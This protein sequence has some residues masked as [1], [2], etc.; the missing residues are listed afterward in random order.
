MPFTKEAVKMALVV[1]DAGEPRPQDFAV[2]LAYDSCT[3]EIPHDIT[4]LKTRDPQ[5]AVRWREATRAAFLAGVEAGFVVEDFW[6]AEVPANGRAELSYT[7]RSLA[8]PDETQDEE[9]ED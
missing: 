9:A 4:A 7:I 6:R 3:I 1:N 8:R 5:A 2:R